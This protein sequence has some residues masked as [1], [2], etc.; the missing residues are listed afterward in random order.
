M[1]RSLA[2]FA[3]LLGLAQPA[4]ADMCTANVGSSPQHCKMPKRRKAHV[5]MT[6]D[7]FGVPHIK[8]NTLYDAG[9]GVGQAQAQDRLFQMEF[10]RK[11]ATGNLAEVAGRDFLGDDE[12][13]RRQFYTEEERQYLFSTLSCPLQTLVQGYVDGVNAYMQQTYGDTT[14]ANVPHE[15]FFLPLL[16][17]ALGAVP[18]GVRYSIETI[19]GKEVYKPDPWRPTDVVAVTVLLAGRFGSG[20]GRQ[21]RQAALVNYLTGFFTTAGPPAGK[22]AAEAARDV[23]EDVRWLDDPKAPTTIPATGAINKVR[24]GKTPVPLA[25]AGVPAPA[26]LVERLRLL[27]SPGLALAAPVDPWAQQHAFVRGLAPSTVLRGL[28]AAERMAAAARRAQR[29]FG[30]FVHWGSNAWVVTPSRTANGAALLWGGPQ[31]GLD[32]PNIDWEAYVRAGRL[33]SGGMMIAGVPGNLIGQTNH[34]AWTTTSGEIDNSTLYVETL[35]EPAPSEPQSVDGAYVFLLNGSYH[36]MD[37]RTETFHFAGEDSSKPPAY[38]P[39]GPA[40]NDGPL[41]YNVFRVNDCDPDHFHGYVLEFDL[42][43]SPPR[44]FTYKTAYWKNETATAEGFLGF[45]LDRGFDEFFASVNEIASLH[46]F[47]YADR[48]GNIAYWSAGSR[49]AFPTGFDD[50]LPA[51]GTGTQEWGLQAGG[52]HYVPFSRS[53]VSVNPTQ[54]YLANW[55]TKPAAG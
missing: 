33:R 42:A 13:A 1:T 39:K 22:T 44:A 2:I 29:K 54:G 6:R 52:A 49:P 8:G 23:F 53:L 26:L 41:L 46:N 51:D 36:P 10:V 17:H 3:L 55:N 32:N 27:F 37:R 7:N 43:A 25:A 38:A 50:R 4:L 31:E 40:L 21:L 9:Y 11:S 34:F 35:Q 45:G 24:G 15:F 18:S 30:T 19:G 14:L 48:R 5:R 47:F 16:V 20:G 28:A 12:D